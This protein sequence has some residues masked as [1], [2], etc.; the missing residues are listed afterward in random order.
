M[1][2][3]LIIHDIR[4]AQNVG[5]LFRTSDSLG[6]NKIYLSE[7][8]PSPIDRFGR[9]RSDIAKTALGAEKNIIWEHYTDILSLIFKYKKDN[10]KII[11]IE[12]S[13]NSVD[14]KNVSASEKIVFIL[15]NEVNGL[16]QEVL[17]IVDVVAE[18][19]MVGQKE[20]LNVAV[21]GGVAMFR[22]LNK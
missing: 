22:I 7:I 10:Y 3:I 19:P 4:S 1:Q 13:D 11:A 2:A 9:A 5:S 15:G 12:Q 8:T 18:I 21:A 20:S 16:S 6:I 17:E 14:Y